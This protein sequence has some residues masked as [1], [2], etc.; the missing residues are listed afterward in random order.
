[1]KKS[2]L[3][4]L[5]TNS[6]E[7]VGEGAAAMTV[8]GAAAA[9]AG[10]RARGRDSHVAG[11][12]LAAND[13]V[14]WTGMSAAARIYVES[15]R[16]SARLRDA[17]DQLAVERAAASASQ[18]ER[19]RQQR[20]L[21]RVTVD[22]RR[23]VAGAADPAL[24]GRLARHEA[25]RL[26][27]VLR[28]GGDAPST[29]DNRLCDIVESVGDHGLRVE[30]VTVELT[31]ELAPDV[32][33]TV[34][35]TVLEALLLAHELGA[36]D[37]SVVR[38]VTEDHRVVITIR[39][40]GEG[41]LSRAGHG[42]RGSLGP[43]RRRRV[44]C[45][46]DASRSR[47][48]PGR[49]V[50]VTLD[51]PAITPDSTP[52]SGADDPADRL[53]PRVLGVVRHVTITVSST[54]ITSTDAAVGGLVW[55]SQHETRRARVDHDDASTESEPLQRCL[56]QRQPGHDPSGRG[57]HPATMTSSRDP[58]VGRTAPFPNGDIGGE[59]ERAERTVL[60]ALLAWRFAGV[61]TGLAPLTAGRKRYRSRT[62]G[63]RS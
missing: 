8:L 10:L 32:A 54:T 35:E 53:P 47:S 52:Q 29:L 18:D 39:D 44:D 16:R 28:M 25:A 6:S 27:H 38:A 46:R 3:V 9:L 56:E 15:H 42:L 14:S 19:I 50:R 7:L 21:H 11:L 48:A 49:W 31:G 12:A 30:L 45:G 22:V 36:A 51:M 62:A 58:V 5:G 1:M 41:F 34:G 63:P 61:A 33:D 17:A 37:R 26:R 43:A 24:A 23:A 59:R 2:P 55:A 57:P 40:Q 4:P 20:R 13:V 60:A